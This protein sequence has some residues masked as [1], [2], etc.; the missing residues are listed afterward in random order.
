M[1][2]EARSS[3]RAPGMLIAGES[4]G[5]PFQRPGMLARA[6]PFAVVAALAEASLA[7]PPGPQ[8]SWAVIASV[9]LLLATACAFALPWSRLPP[10]MP[11][12]VPLA[13]TAS[14]LALILAAGANSGVG[15]VILIP[16]VW[17]ALFHRRW[18]SACIVV[19][20][21][22]VEVVISLTPVPA[23]DAVIGRRVLLWASL[24][25]LISVAA[26]GLRDRIARAQAERG[27]LQDQLRELT[28]IEDRERIAATLSDNVVQQILAA[29]LT[30]QAVADMT[31]EAEVRRRVDACV[32]GLD[33]A[34]RTLRDAIF[35][36]ETRSRSAGLRQEVLALCRELSPVPEIS[37]SAEPDGAM[38]VQAR[39][40]TLGLLCESFSLIGPDC[41][42]RRVEVTVA[43]D[44]CVVAIDASSRDHP[45]KG[46]SSAESFS[47]LLE[48]ARRPGVQV[49]VET[50][51]GGIR[52]G[53]RFSL[54]R[55]PAP[56]PKAEHPF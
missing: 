1:R 54:D 15:V 10:W 41:V 16:L 19:A 40:Q 23:P 6:A 43:G 29:G 11:V 42:P 55:S 36:L 25:A 18:E 34:V 26:H 4:N 52:L 13:Y 45:T 37:F 47:G 33:R 21:V 51:P 31:A 2:P 27:R 22:T 24:G 44:A 17:T 48:R 9:V 56:P 30:L 14:V 53:W 39:A 28:L 7:L 49:D 50:I 8:S 32:E 38:S 20:I 35:G 5:S 12:L 3:T 46:L